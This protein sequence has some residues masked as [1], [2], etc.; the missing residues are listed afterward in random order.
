MLLLGVSRMTYPST[1]P[2]TTTERDLIGALWHTYPREKTGATWAEGRE[3]WTDRQCNAVAKKAMKICYP[4][5][6][7]TKSLVSFLGPL[8]PSAHALQ[9][10]IGSVTAALIQL[11][12]LYVPEQSFTSCTGKWWS[13]CS[14]A[15]LYPRKKN[16]SDKQKKISAQFGRLK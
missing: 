6:S 11:K 14:P 5:R 15:H 2:C 7:P 9:M 3:R 10:P 16:L 12:A 1:K 8:R 4:G 13:R